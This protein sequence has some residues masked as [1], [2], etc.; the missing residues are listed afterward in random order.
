MKFTHLATLAILAWSTAFP[1][2]AADFDTA[3]GTALIEK[4]QGSLVEVRATLAVKPELIE[5]PPGVGDM[6]NQQPETKQAVQTEG[7][8]I[9]GNG[10]VAVPLAALDPSGI[11]GTDGMEVETP[12]GKLK[13]GMKSTI[14]SVTIVTADGK[15]FPADVIFKDAKSGLALV[16]PTAPPAEPLAAVA[17]TKNLPAPTLFSRVYAMNRLTTEFG[18][19]PTLRVIRTGVVTPAPVPLIDIADKM[20]EPGSAVFDRDGRFIG[21]VVLPFRS[22]PGSMAELRLCI[23]PLSEILRLGAKAML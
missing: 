13:I 7:V 21:I 3:A 8:L 5:G 18:N 9:H 4:N 10:L 20:V 17:L 12:L 22:K 2:Q 19:A 23:L 11:M 15:E 1:L 16:K 14:T 6:I